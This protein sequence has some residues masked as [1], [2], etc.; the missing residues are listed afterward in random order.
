MGVRHISVLSFVRNCTSS[1]EM[2][3]RSVSQS[4]SEVMVT[5]VNE[6]VNSPTVSVLLTKAVNVLFIDTPFSIQAS[7]NH[8]VRCAP[9][10]RC[11]ID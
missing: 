5:E 1:F 7:V 3:A 8:L 2:H 6:I 11:E 4:V 9:E 10:S